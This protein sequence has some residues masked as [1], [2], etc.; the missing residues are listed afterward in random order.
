MPIKAACSCGHSFDAPSKYAGKKVKCPKC[1]EP[2]QVPAG[3]KSGKGGKSGT[4]KISVKCGCGK[5]FQVKAEL[6]G[7]RVKC[8]GCGAPLTIQA[9]ESTEKKKSKPIDQESMMAEM[10]DEIGFALDDGSKG[11]KCPECKAPMQPE[12]I[13]CID[14]GYNE[15]LGKKMKTFRPVTAEDRAK[16]ASR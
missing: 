1:K 2:L 4:S 7:K 15:T 9:A 10:F 8:P 6:A 13:I 12:A 16:K 11:R 3:N 14:C 5:D